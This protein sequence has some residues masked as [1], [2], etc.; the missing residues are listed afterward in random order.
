MEPQYDQIG[1]S[2]DPVKLIP[3]VRYGERPTLG[4]LLPDVR[5]R[6]VLD[7]ACGTGFYARECV[8]LGAQRVVGVDISSE[9]I[10]V[11]R[12]ADER[13]QFGIEYHVHDARTMPSLGTFDVA[14]AVY[15]FN[16]AATANDLDMMFKQV[17]LNLAPHGYVIGFAADGS[18]V[19]DTDSRKYG[20][21]VNFLGEVDDGY[22]AQIVAHLPDGDIDFETFFLSKACYERAARRAGFV[23]EWIPLE[24][25]GDGVEAFEPGFWDDYLRN[26]SVVAF[27]ATRG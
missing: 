10:S 18:H 27:R 12:K 9:M 2:Y 21:S 1:A 4:R 15:L 11:A 22:R 20:A 6:T 16:N 23:V 8:R 13:D 14:L 5:G 26:P 25:D 7:V 19:V 17:A 3:I 24:I